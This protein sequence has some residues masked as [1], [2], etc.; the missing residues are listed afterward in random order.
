MTGIA[1]AQE[2]SLGDVFARAASR[3]VMIN[4]GDEDGTGYVMASS[5]KQVLIA[6]S[7]HVVVPV[8]EAKKP[9]I[10][11][12]WVSAPGGCAP[13]PRAISVHWLEQAD[14]QAFD[15]ALIVADAGCSPDL[16]TVP[17]AWAGGEPSPG[18]RFH[19]VRV[20]TGEPP[21]IA[22]VGPFW[23]A[24]DCLKSGQCINRTR[25]ELWT[26][27]FTEA[28][29]SGSPVVTQAGIA[30]IVRGGNYVSAW[31]SAEITAAVC[32]GTRVPNTHGYNAVG[33]TCRS[34]PDSVPIPAAL[35]QAGPTPLPPAVQG[36]CDP[37]TGQPLRDRS[38]IGTSYKCRLENLA[39]DWESR[40]GRLNCL[41]WERCRE[42]W[43]KAVADNGFTL[44]LNPPAEWT[45]L[46]DVLE[47]RPYPA[48]LVLSHPDRIADF[49]TEFEKHGFVS[50]AKDHSPTVPPPSVVSQADGP[51]CLVSQEWRT[52]VHP[53]ARPGDLMADHLSSSGD[54][55][56]ASVDY[57]PLEAKRTKYL[58]WKPTPAGLQVVA[59]RQ[60]QE[61]GV[62]WRST[63]TLNA[64]HLFVI[65]IQLEGGD[66][67]AGYISAVNLWRSGERQRLKLSGTFDR[68]A[69]I[70]FQ[71]GWLAYVPRGRGDTA[72]LLFLGED[73][74]VKKEVI[75]SDL[76]G[77]HIGGPVLSFN[78]QYLAIYGPDLGTGVGN[79]ID[80]FIRD[81][82]RWLL[83]GDVKLPAE[84]TMLDLDIRD[85][86]LAILKKSSGRIIVELR[87]QALQWKARAIIR[88]I[89]TYERQER[90]RPDYDVPKVLIAGG[91]VVVGDPRWSSTKSWTDEKMGALHVFDVGQPSSA[92]A[93]TLV[94][95][96]RK[97]WDSF[98]SQLALVGH[99]VLARGVH[100]REN[101]T[102]EIIAIDVASLKELVSTCQSK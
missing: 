79:G 21:V 19:A 94:Q 92:S 35:A 10:A 4:A 6:T 33:L 41:D 74:E 65:S 71:Q 2:L 96:Q 99:Q 20:T 61:Q 73:A 76:A 90:E 87:E 66:R 23:F 28:G 7:R 53:G 75:L 15:V 51:T 11:L 46:L 24:D 50:P 70:K 78:N 38:E 39:R 52:F 43:L 81:G 67:S 37:R 95:E 26:Q 64:N 1:A 89:A 34:A 102:G 9:A 69:A 31:P 82:D 97:G 83:D 98:G 27:G 86:S 55:V 8:L 60:N 57:G 13:S 32:A 16:R 22:G 40:A 30:G 77:R 45:A 72:K 101:N 91:F 3:V 12:R 49:R 68:S 42:P 25:L 58:V 59:E 84:D 48:D 14:R 54:L 5:G 88:T 93:V 62:A 100:N 29:M 85:G 56:L 47:L 36:G 80:I 44:G 17:S 63:A 18:S